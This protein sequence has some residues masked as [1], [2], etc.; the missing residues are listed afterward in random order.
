MNYKNSGIQLKCAS[1][2]HVF[3]PSL[4]KR[5]KH[6][7]ILVTRHSSEHLLQEAKA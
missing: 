5:V 1:L 3:L 6:N 4:R 2:K 7:I